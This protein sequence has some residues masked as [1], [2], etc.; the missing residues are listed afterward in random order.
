[1]GFEPGMAERLQQ[2]LVDAVSQREVNG[3]PSVLLVPAEIRTGI[4]R[5]LKHSLPV[6]HVL[7]Y[8]EVPQDKQIKIVSTV[9]G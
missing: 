2:S 7:S 1:M 8:S 5:W 3:E 6:L 9:G 4:S